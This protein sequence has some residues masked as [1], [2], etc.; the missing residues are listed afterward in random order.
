[1][2]TMLFALGLLGALIACESPND[3]ETVAPGSRQAARVAAGGPAGSAGISTDHPP[4][5]LGSVVVYTFNMSYE[6]SL[7]IYVDDNT[8]PSGTLKAVW[9]FHVKPTCQTNLAEKAA[10]ITH[11]AG[12]H[13]LKIYGYKN[14]YHNAA[15]FYY[16]INFNKDCNNTFRLFQLPVQP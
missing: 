6:D 2:K 9:P 15:W 13:T 3:R 12:R 5:N 14:G 1:M 10:K 16:D 4:L 7:V 8:K 11:L